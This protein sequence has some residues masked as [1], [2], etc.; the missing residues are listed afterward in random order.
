M[1]TY[2]RV[3]KEQLKTDPDSI[4]EIGSR[5]GDSAEELRALASLDPKCVYIVEPH[6]QS[7]RNIIHDYPRFNVFPFAISDKIGVLDFNAI[8]HQFGIENVG[9]SS[10]LKKNEDTYLKVASKLMFDA[11][12]IQ[13]W[14]K[15]L[16]ISGAN[17][18]QLI[19]LTEIDMVKIDVEGMTY[20][21]LKSFG[22]DIRLL[23]SLHI[24]VEHIKIWEN[25]HVYPEIKD[26]LGYYNFQEMY[27]IPLYFGGNQGDAV[28]IRR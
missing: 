6:P 24:E 23:K 26:L 19:N 16:S 22:D 25:Q 15:V 8:P 20:E 5:D 14:I 3:Y 4:L 2:H 9:T 28:W 21:V 18:L 12:N 27:Y 7:F 17:L 13:N 11:H 10:L 1:K